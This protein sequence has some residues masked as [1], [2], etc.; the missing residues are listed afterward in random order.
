MAPSSLPGSA[1]SFLSHLSHILRS[2]PGG[3]MAA[4]A[5]SSCAWSASAAPA[6]KFSCRLFAAQASPLGATPSASES[7]RPVFAQRQL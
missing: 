4:S 5:T 6:V 1:P 3:W 2:A 7:A